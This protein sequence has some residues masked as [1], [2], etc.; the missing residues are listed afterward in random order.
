MVSV[1]IWDRA[2]LV[3]GSLCQYG[4]AVGV[5]D[6]Y[7]DYWSLNSS[8]TSLTISNL[9]QRTKKCEDKNVRWGGESSM[10]SSSLE[11][12]DRNLTNKPQNSLPSDIQ[13]A[14]SF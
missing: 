13:L 12:L 8:S 6:Y 1:G 11:E 9:L 3:M 7:W 2:F 4:R 10:L 14:P 5:P